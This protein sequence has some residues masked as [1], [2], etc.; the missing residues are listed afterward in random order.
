MCVCWTQQFDIYCRCRDGHKKFTEAGKDHS[1]GAGHGESDAKKEERNQLA[2]CIDLERSAKEAGEA[3]REVNKC[4]EQLRTGEVNDMA[5]E[6]AAKDAPLR[7]KAVK[8]LASRLRAAKMRKLSF[9]QSNKGQ[10]YTYGEAD[11]QAFKQWQQL[12]QMDKELPDPFPSECVPLPRTLLQR[13]MLAHARVVGLQ[14]RCSSLAQVHAGNGVPERVRAQ[15]TRDARRG[16]Q[17]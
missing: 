2:A 9:E 4:F 15:R 8:I 14:H 5:I 6:C 17:S 11:L 3:K 13:L 7:I 10:Q 16:L 1:G 12:R